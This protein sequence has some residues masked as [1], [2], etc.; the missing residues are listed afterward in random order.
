MSKII[1]FEQN[2]GKAHINYSTKPDW[3][4]EDKVTFSKDY[5]I[6]GKMNKHHLVKMIESTYTYHI[7]DSTGV[8]IERSVSAFETAIMDKQVFLSRILSEIIP[9]V[10]ERGA[11]FEQQPVTNEC[12]HGRKEKLPASGKR[13]G[14]AKNSD[15]VEITDADFVALVVCLSSLSTINRYLLPNNIQGQSVYIPKTLMV[16]SSGSQNSWNQFLVPVPNSI[17]STRIVPE[18]K[19]DM[20]FQG[21]PH[22]DVHII[23]KLNCPILGHKIYMP[24]QCHLVIKYM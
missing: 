6:T 18:S 4:D 14:I 15:K 19:S 23:W 22:P 16:T 17:Y 7:T 13:L 12:T 11:N 2:L 20:D 3:W 1:Q 21:V 10:Q 24:H 8:H 9:E 5:S